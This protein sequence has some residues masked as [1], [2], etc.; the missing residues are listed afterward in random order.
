MY[1]VMSHKV[2]SLAISRHIF[3]III[4]FCLRK[5]IQI[6]LSIVLSTIIIFCFNSFKII[7]RK[8]SH[9]FLI[10]IIVAIFPRF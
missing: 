5:T 4:V 6:V 9:I 1:L 2:R 8:Y 7:C 3:Y 10:T